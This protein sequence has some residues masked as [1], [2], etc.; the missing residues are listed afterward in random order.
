MPKVNVHI[1]FE[2]LCDGRHEQG[3]YFCG[4]MVDLLRDG[5]RVEIETLDGTLT[6][7][8]ATDFEVWYKR[9]VPRLA[10]LHQTLESRGQ[11]DDDWAAARALEDVLGSNP[12]QSRGDQVTR[13][14]KLLAKYAA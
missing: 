14:E 1:S 6:F 3:Q 10:A 4:A 13:A 12:G 5:C 11:K 9:L 8:A 7:E 2:T